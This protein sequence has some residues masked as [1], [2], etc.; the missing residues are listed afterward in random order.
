MHLQCCVCDNQFRL[1]LNVCISANQNDTIT[2]GSS[3]QSTTSSTAKL[4]LS[5][6]YSAGY[7][8]SLA[9]LGG[10]ANEV[11]V[12]EVERLLQVEVLGHHVLHQVAGIYVQLCLRT[13]D[14]TLSGTL[15][16]AV[17]QGKLR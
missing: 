8:V 4:A 3:I 14:L 1:S 5:N 6:Y 10:P 12:G 7:S 15:E 17:N 16:R 2:A 9:F 11:G 13:V